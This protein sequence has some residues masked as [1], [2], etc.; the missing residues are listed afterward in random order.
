[1][2]ARHPGI[3]YSITIRASYAIE[4]GILGRITSAIGEAGVDIGAIDVNST[5]RDSMVRDI[6]VNTRD[7][8]HSQEV[9]EDAEFFGYWSNQHLIGGQ[10]EAIKVS[11]YRSRRGGLFCVYNITR[12]PQQA[13][14]EI[15][16][17][18]W[19][20]RGYP[21]DVDRRDAYTKE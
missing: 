12:Q 14:L 3:A 17:R 6:T 13:T 21:N 2:A 20:K 7:V 10:T 9:I 5:S 19:M 15:D 18:K 1:M 8:P 11:A 4:V 16:W